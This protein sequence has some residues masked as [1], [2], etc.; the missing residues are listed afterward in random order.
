MNSNGIDQ[1]SQ[2][3]S[4]SS[5]PLSSTQADL[6]NSS[7]LADPR[8][9]RP[10]LKRSPCSGFSACRLAC[11]L[12]HTPNN[13]PGHD[14]PALTSNLDSAIKL[15]VSFLRFPFPF[16]LPSP[17]PVRQHAHTC[18]P[19]GHLPLIPGSGNFYFFLFPLNLFVILLLFYFC[20]FFS[21]V[22]FSFLFLSPRII[23]LF[24]SLAFEFSL[25]RKGKKV[26]ENLTPEDTPGIDDQSTT[27]QAVVRGFVFLVSFL[28]AIWLRLVSYANQRSQPAVTLVSRTIIF[29]LSHTL[30]SREFGPPSTAPFAFCRLS[31]ISGFLLFGRS[32]V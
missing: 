10:E 9:D 17:P 11:V 16:F 5:P 15:T 24:I 20:I 23:S 32:Y 3:I 21:V 12:S 4:P 25:G 22:V 29:Y 6:S 27:R 13:L 18:N 14:L 7:N 19:L 31:S 30:S 2:Q 26:S 28:T 1:H 8:K